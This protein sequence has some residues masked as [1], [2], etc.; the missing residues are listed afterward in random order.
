MTYV[1]K[2]HTIQAVLIEF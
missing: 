2:I 1:Q